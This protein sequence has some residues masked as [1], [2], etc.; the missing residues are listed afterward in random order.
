[1][2][3]Y[4]FIHDKASNLDGETFFAVWEP[5]MREFALENGFTYNPA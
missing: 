4:R 3:W 1:M 2:N 5:S